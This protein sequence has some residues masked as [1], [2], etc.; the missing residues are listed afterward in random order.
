MQIFITVSLLSK[1]FTAEKE[2]LWQ[3]FE[4]ESHLAS[5]ILC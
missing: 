5:C 1:Y 3:K 4:K 2:I